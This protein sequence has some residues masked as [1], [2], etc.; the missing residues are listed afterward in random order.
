[1]DESVAP[2]Y[3]QHNEGPF[4]AASYAE[5]YN[6][7]YRRYAPIDA[8]KESN[9][10]TL[11]ATPLGNI[12][13]CLVQHRPLEGVASVPPGTIDIGSGGRPMEYQEEN[14]LQNLGRWEGVIDYYPDDSRGRGVE[15]Y[16]Q[17]NALAKKKKDDDE[18][19]ELV[20]QNESKA[21]SSSRCYLDT[22]EGEIR[23]RHRSSS[24]GKEF[25]N[26]LKKRSG[27]NQD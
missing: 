11:D 27:N 12:E 5:N 13:D 14:L 15:H 3:Q 23:T 1:M 24:G 16:K 21:E 6:R 18:G 2:E 19:Y 9:Q 20:N 26:G 22:Y 10:L 8:L 4:D 7:N 25:L 17:L